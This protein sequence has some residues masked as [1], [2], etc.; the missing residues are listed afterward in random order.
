VIQFCVLLLK[1]FFFPVALRPN[2]ANC[3]LILK[4]S[5]S[6]KWGPTLGLFWTNNRLIAE[7]DTWQHNNTHNWQTSLS[8][9]GIEP[10]ISAGERL[11]THALGRAATRIGFQTLKLCKY[12]EV[13]EK[14]HMDRLHLHI[15]LET[16]RSPIYVPLP[17]PSPIVMALTRASRLVHMCRRGLEG[18]K[19]FR[20]PPNIGFLDVVFL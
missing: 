18:S 12:T 3:L 5:R 10:A 9:A 8:Q 13:K 14:S 6:Q 7:T 17:R 4:V 16:L 19:I 1:V 2:V 20:P 11:K 15:Y